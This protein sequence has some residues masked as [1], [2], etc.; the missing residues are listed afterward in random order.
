MTLQRQVEAH[1]QEPPIKRR[2]I[3]GK[4]PD[5]VGMYAISLTVAAG[6]AASPRLAAGEA[7]D[8]R[9][10]GKEMGDGQSLPARGSACA[11]A[12]PHAREAPVVTTYRRDDVVATASGAADAAA[13]EEPPDIDAYQFDGTRLM[14]G[15]A[16]DE[17]VFNFAGDMGE[18]AYF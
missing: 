11:A 13:F 3:R 17:D 1:V 2:R 16:E 8:S 6:D 12:D 18:A 7:D 4:Q 14:V 15:A 10:D 9:D 5:V